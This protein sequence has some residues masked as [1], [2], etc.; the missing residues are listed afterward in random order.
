LLGSLGCFVLKPGFYLDTIFSTNLS[1]K[2]DYLRK[3]GALEVWIM[4]NITMTSETLERY[5][6]VLKGFDNDSKEKLIKKLE[7]SI[8][9]EKKFIDPQTLFGAWEDDKTSDEIIKEIRESRV[10]KRESTSF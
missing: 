2:V 5:F 4:G 7:E 8:H 10:E 1:P 3:L 6:E 9:R